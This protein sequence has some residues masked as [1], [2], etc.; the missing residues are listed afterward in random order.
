MVRID[1][2]YQGDLH[3]RALHGP[4]KHSL[5]TD[6][7]TDNGGE[8][9]SFSPTDLVATAF[10]TC[11]ATILGLQAKKSGLDLTGMRIEVTKEM[12]PSNPRRIA[13]LSTVVR[14]PIAISADPGRAL[15]QS[16][17]SCP[18]GRS[19]HPE[20]EKPIAFLYRAG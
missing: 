15:E 10:G 3:C 9:G 5:K 14:L 18:V 11:V 1:I 12:T 2:E 20:I 17:A 16:V 13:R 19:L 8:G 4:S 6:A 7:P